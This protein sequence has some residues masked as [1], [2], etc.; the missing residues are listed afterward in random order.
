MRSFYEVTDKMRE[1][2]LADG[3]IHVVS[4]GDPNEVDWDKQ[5]VFPLAHVVPGSATLRGSTTVLSFDIALVD[6]VNQTREED[7]DQHKPF[8]GSDNTQD[9]LNTQLA[10]AIRL[11]EEFRRGDTWDLGYDVE[12]DWSAAPLMDSY[13]NLLAGWVISMDVIV[14]N[15]LMCL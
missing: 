8:Q 15:N 5:T 13:T 14:P 7:R 4:F 3:D 9:I 1:L 6:K 2:L 11:R 12:V 10:V